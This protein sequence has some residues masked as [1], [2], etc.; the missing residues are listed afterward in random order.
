MLTQTDPALIRARQFVRNAKMGGEDPRC[1]PVFGGVGAGN[2][3]VQRVELQGRD[4]RPKDFLARDGHL[5]GDLTKD[6]GGDEV[7][8]VEIPA[9]QPSAAGQHRRP[10]VTA[11]GQKA[12]DPPRLAVRNDRTDFRFLQDTVAD[13]QGGGIVGHPAREFVMDLPRDK[14]TR[15]C[16]ADLP[17]I[18]KDRHG[19]DRHSLIDISVAADDH[20]RLAAQLQRN[21]FEI[22]GCCTG[23]RL[24]RRGRTGEDDLVHLRM[25]RPRRRPP[26]L[27][28]R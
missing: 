16:D 23:D 17:R 1:Q 14:Q 2:N 9:C 13:P 12:F 10:F 11:H 21:A 18:G 4:H 24:P 19:G 3:L 22:A 20:R 25:S 26:R 27:L 5:V 7:S 6:C 28:C 8:A 15:A